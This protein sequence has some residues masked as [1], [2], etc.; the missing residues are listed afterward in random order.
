MKATIEA[1]PPELLA[2]VMT[3]GIYLVGGG[4]L[5]TGFSTLLS[6]AT[7]MRV[8]IIEDPLTAVARG[9]GI[10]LE[11]LDDL[12]VFFSVANTADSIYCRLWYYGTNDLFYWSCDLGD[13]SQFFSSADLINANEWV[14]QIMWDRNVID[15]L[16]KQISESGR[17]TLD[18]TVPMQG[19]FIINSK[20]RKFALHSI[21]LISKVSLDRASLPFERMLFLSLSAKT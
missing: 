11:N 6:Q 9:G 7:K 2:D 18:L 17:Y 14:K 8:N 10:V 5:L 21:Q 1:T 16:Q 13:T 20:G 3:D 15:A 12:M 4:S 19:S